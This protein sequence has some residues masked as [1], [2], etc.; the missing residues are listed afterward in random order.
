[1]KRVIGFIAVLVLLFLA[2][3]ALA[4]TVS[5]KEGETQ[6]N[7]RTEPSY[8]AKP[9]GYI[10]AGK[11]YEVVG[12]VLSWVKAVFE[13]PKRGKVEGW[14]GAKILVLTNDERRIGGQGCTLRKEPNSRKKGTADGFLQKGSLLVKQTDK[15][16]NFYRVKVDGKEV[17]VSGSYCVLKKGK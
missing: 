13:D 11:D 12:E 17:Y 2:V 16:V 15:V 1:M 9:A 14:V 6:L 4:D 7:Y 10:E 3:P 5:V 8:K